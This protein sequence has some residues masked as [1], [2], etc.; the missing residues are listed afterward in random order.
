MRH[1]TVLAAIAALP[2]MAATP[3][4]IGA[5]CWGGAY[6]ILSWFDPEQALID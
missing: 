1:P 6:R 4:S 2:A 3:V 5:A